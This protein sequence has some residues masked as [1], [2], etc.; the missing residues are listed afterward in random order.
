MQ[1]SAFLKGQN[2]SWPSVA[3]YPLESGSPTAPFVSES[4]TGP[5]GGY[6]PALVLSAI[7]T[8]TVTV[9][10][11]VVFPY[12]RNNHGKCRLLAGQ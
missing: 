7:P 2:P 5:A 4:A 1:G 3:P 6:N 11:S 8:G 12:W 10:H 9:H